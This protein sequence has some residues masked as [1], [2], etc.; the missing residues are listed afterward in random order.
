MKGWLIGISM[1][2]MWGAQRQRLEVPP[3]EDVDAE[4]P[5]PRSQDD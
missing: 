5:Q 3:G 4:D 2:W 1:V